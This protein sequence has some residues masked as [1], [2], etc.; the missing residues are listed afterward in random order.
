MRVK[1]YI[2]QNILFPIGMKNSRILDGNSALKGLSEAY[3]FNGDGYTVLPSYTLSSNGATGGLVSCADDMAIYLTSILNDH[4]NVMG[5]GIAKAAIADMDRIHSSMA[6]EQGLQTGYA[7]GNFI[8]PNNSK[9]TFRGHSGLGEGFNSWV[10]YSKAAGIAYAIANNSGRNNWVI[11]QI[12]ESFITQHIKAEPLVQSNESISR[13]Q[14][15][16]GYYAFANPKNERWDF[17]HRIFDGVDLSIVGNT[18]I[19]KNNKGNTDTLIHVEKNI[20]RFKG[21]HIP[22]FVLGRD[23]NGK[24]FIQAYGNSL[25]FTQAERAPILMQQYL[26]YMGILSMVLSLVF[27]FAAGVFLLLRK[28]KTQLFILIL[29]PAL[30]TINGLLAYR[31]LV[32]TDELHKVAFATANPT[33]LFI[34]IGSLGFGVFTLVSLFL[35]VRYWKSFSYKWLRITFVFVVGLLTYLSVIFFIHGWIGLCI[36]RV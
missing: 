20:F 27:A 10:F 14:S 22:S 34:F 7:I 33:T 24:A 25:F 4:Q 29:M 26:F 36:W 6:S 17:L 21:D 16:A 28:I 31:K 11:S 32:L 3:N 15:F 13:F 2:E 1:D 12:I 9:V 19:L 30:A 8:F 23:R 18:M 35:L 5:I